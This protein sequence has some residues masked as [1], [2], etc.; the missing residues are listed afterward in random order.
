MQ[1]SEIMTLFGYNYW[2]NARIL[3]AAAKVTPAQFTAVVGT[4]YSSLRGT[5]VHT[6]GVEWLYR[7]RCQEGLSPDHLPPVTDFPTF[8]SLRSKWQAEEQA[9]R[10]YVGGLGDNDLT[11]RVAYKTTSG[12]PYENVLWGLL[13]QVVLHGAQDRSEA[14]MAL[15]RFRQSPG[16]IDFILYLRER[17]A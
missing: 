2:A 15:T 7:V 14:A 8:E 17:S 11:R 5:L 10:A 9:M 13:L 3:D 16:D 6:Y 4:S 1:A 12:V